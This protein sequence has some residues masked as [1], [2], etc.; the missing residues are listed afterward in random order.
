MSLRWQLLA[1]YAI[2][3]A[4]VSLSAAVHIRADLERG[5]DV[6]LAM[7]AHFLLGGALFGLA[8][9]VSL[10]RPRAATGIAL[11]AAAVSIVR[12]AMSLCGFSYWAFLPL[13]TVEG[14]WAY[15]LPPA[16][17]TITV[18]YA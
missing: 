3:A 16:V 11:G 5:D 18:A 10:I 6:G 14:F 4:A 17:L 8:A 12:Y 15:G 9:L 7:A 13:F 2:S 1:L